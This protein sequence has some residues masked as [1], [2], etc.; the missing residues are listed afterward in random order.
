MFMLANTKHGILDMQYIS[1]EAFTACCFSRKLFL[2]GRLCIAP[3]RAT[4]WDYHEC[5]VIWTFF[6][7]WRGAFYSL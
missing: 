1:L 5:R 4:A 2:C 3:E 7:L 6:L